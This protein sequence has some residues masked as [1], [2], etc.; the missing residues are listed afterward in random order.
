[1]KKT[2]KILLLLLVCVTLGTLTGCSNENVTGDLTDIMEKVYEKMYSDVKE[3]DRPML[4][5]TN[6]LNPY[7]EATQEEIDNLIEYAIGTKEIE[8]KEIVYSEPPM[9]SIAYSVV[10]VRMKDG[11]NIEEAKTKIKESVNPRK[12][13]CVEVAKED[14]IVKNKGDLI[15]VIMVADENLRES[16][17]KGF[18]NL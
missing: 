13:M 5:T 10:L 8:Y 11:A 4:Q 9:S 15:I 7:D 1:M 6:A 2:T 3:E 16:I 14:I 18:D 12:W 17:E